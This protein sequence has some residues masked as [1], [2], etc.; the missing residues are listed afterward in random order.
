MLNSHAKT[1]IQRQIDETERWIDERVD[2][3][4]GLTDDQIRLAEGRPGRRRR[5][6]RPAPAAPR[7]RHAGKPAARRLDIHQTFT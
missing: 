4:F 1:A 2:G 5:V 3:R 7:P 6:T